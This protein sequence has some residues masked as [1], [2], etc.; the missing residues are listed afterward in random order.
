MEEQF[1]FECLK[2]NLPFYSVADTYSAEKLGLIRRLVHLKGT[3]QGFWRVLVTVEKDL[4]L[5]LKSCVCFATDGAS[6]M[7]KVGKIIRQKESGCTTSM[8]SGAWSGFDRE[9]L[10][11]WSKECLPIRNRFWEIPRLLQVRLIVRVG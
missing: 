7:S 3:Y 4:Q 10:H 9:K 2:G 1:T 8:V 6:L 11:V 5:T